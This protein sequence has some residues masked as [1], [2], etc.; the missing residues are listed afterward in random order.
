M[1]CCSLYHVPPF[2]SHNTIQHY[3]LLFG[4]QVSAHSTRDELNELQ[5]YPKFARTNPS[6]IDTS[7]VI[8]SY[9]IHKYDI[10]NNE[11]YVAIIFSNGNSGRDFN[12]ILTEQLRKKGIP[13]TQI[14]GI[15]VDKNGDNISD[16]IEVLQNLRFHYIITVLDDL[17]KNGFDH[18]MKEIV[19]TNLGYV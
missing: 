19:Q 18:L 9:L 10:L 4:I 8:V 17:T 6:Y 13:R 3:I 5:T 7:Q 11:P 15:S 16:R 1:R 12:S 14:R 2:L